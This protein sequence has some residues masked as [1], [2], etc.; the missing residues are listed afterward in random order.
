[1]ESSRS[2]SDGSKVNRRCANVMLNGQFV[3]EFVSLW[4][5]ISKY[6]RRRLYQDVEKVTFRGSTHFLVF[7]QPDG[8]F[9]SERVYF[10]Y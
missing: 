2:K 6:L 7:Q 8:P 4:D 9:E 3:V 5:K 10:F 1:M